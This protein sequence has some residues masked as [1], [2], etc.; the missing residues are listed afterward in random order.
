MNKED[1]CGPNAAPFEIR[2]Q[3]GVK[4][5][6][7]S[8]SLTAAGLLLQAVDELLGGDTLAD[9]S[10]IAKHH[11]ATFAVGTASALNAERERLG[12]GTKAEN[13]SRLKSD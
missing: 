3:N 11:G 12:L 4:L 10:G 8:L 2:D 5:I 7:G 9:Y 1:L 13:P 6:Y